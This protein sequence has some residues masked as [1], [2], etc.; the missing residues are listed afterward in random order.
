MDQMIKPE[1]TN[2]RWQGLYKLGSIAALMIAA[3]LLGEIAVFAVLPMP[4]TTVEY[5]ALFRDNWLVGLLTLDLLGMISYILFVPMIIALYMTLR[6]TSETVMVVATALFFVGI[7]DFFATNTAFPMLS[8]SSQY[9]AAQTN[10]ER[11]MLLAAGQTMLTLFDE[12]AFLVSYV[13]VSAAW[14]M[15]SGSMLRSN[16]FSRITAYAGI[17]A[18]TAGIVAVVLEHIL[19][20]DAL[21]IAIAL[22][23][24]AIALLFIW[25]VLAGRRLYQLHTI[26]ATNNDTR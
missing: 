13:I 23:F 6:R 22:Y 20:K 11:A 7:A 1:I 18:G 16:T 24:A 14:T 21:F 12:N 3:L 5:F 19:I 25:V 26:S 2:S 17:L 4:I 9:A 15:I 10:A 8:L